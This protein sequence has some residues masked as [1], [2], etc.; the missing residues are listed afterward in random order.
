MH[1]RGR[2]RCRGRP[3]LRGL[4]DHRLRVAVPE[5]ADVRLPLP[6]WILLVEAVILWGLVGYESKG[7]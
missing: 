2:L 7:W 1:A 5:G 3:W 4:S 6:L